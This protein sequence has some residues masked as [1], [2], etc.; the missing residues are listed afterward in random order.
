[1]IIAFAFL[2]LASSVYAETWQEYRNRVENMSQRVVDCGFF[3]GKYWMDKYAAVWA[4]HDWCYNQFK[5]ILDEDNTMTPPIRTGRVL[6]MNMHYM[7]GDKYAKNA[8]KVSSNPYKW[9]C[10]RY[11]YWYN[12]LNKGGWIDFNKF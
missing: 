1:M 5:Y 10:Q 9:M 12:H 3:E 11:D 8:S 7:E 2:I 4:T 6:L